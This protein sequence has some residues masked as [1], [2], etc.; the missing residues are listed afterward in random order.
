[1]KNPPDYQGSHLDP[2]KLKKRAPR[3]GFKR[4]KGIPAARRHKVSA[5]SMS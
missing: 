4:R 1:M 5:F 2:E 3:L